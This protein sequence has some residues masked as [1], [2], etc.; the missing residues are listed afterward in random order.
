MTVILSLAFMSLG[1]LSQ[2]WRIWQS[3]NVAGVSL[4][5][6]ALLAIQSLFWVLYGFQKKDW[7]II[8]PNLLG[9]LFAT[10]IVLEYFWFR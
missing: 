2:V 3:E 9:T 10:I 1:L 4:L 7:F 8:T 5:A 6:F